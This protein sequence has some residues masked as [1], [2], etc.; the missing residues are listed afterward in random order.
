MDPTVDRS[1]TY[2][3]ANAPALLFRVRENGDVMFLFLPSVPMYKSEPKI[4]TPRFHAQRTP[5]FFP[6]L[7]TLHQPRRRHQLPGRQ[8]HEPLLFGPRTV[9]SLDTHSGLERWVT[10]A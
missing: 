7:V 5:Q 8:R 6:F 9:C 4:P 3:F 10:R 2:L 1:H